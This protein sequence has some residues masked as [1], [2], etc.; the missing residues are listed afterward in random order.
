MFRFHA[1][2]PALVPVVQELRATFRD[3]FTSIVEAIY[4]PRRE[5]IREFA[6]AFRLG[7]EKKRGDDDG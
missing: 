2:D 6:D 3:R 7:K 5:N 4:E 1:A